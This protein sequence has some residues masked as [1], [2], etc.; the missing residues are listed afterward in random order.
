VNCTCV[1]IIFRI[2]LIFVGVYIYII[3]R[4]RNKKNKQNTRNISTCSLPKLPVSHPFLHYTY[5]WTPLTPPS[6]GR[7]PAPHPH[8]RT[9]QQPPLSAFLSPLPRFSHRVAQA[10]DRRRARPRAPA[11]RR[12]RPD[13]TQWIPAEPLRPRPAIRASAPARPARSDPATASCVPSLME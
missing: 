1:N 8:A 5:M 4:F 6:S 12:P 10:L 9:A 3:E 13:R 11:A 2:F 7:L